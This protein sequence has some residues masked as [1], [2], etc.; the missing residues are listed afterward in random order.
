MEGREPIL[1]VQ[2]CT[3]TRSRQ[4]SPRAQGKKARNRRGKI[5]SEGPACD[6]REELYILHCH[7]TGQTPEADYSS[8]CFARFGSAGPDWNDHRCCCGRFLYAHALEGRQL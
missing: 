7:H 1:T 8:I 4:L 6:K 5:R 3:V 2:I